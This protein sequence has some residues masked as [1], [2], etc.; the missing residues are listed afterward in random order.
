M[1]LTAVHTEI[2]QSYDASCW[3][4]LYSP[5]RSKFPSHQPAAHISTHK[6]TYSQHAVYN[7]FTQLVKKGTPKLT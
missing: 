7:Q 2:K 3:M 5:H 6:R 1:Q 4:F